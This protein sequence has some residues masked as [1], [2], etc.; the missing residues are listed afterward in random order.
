MSDSND[1]SGGPT[2]QH[3]SRRQLLSGA[4][5]ALGAAFLMPDQVSARLSALGSEEE[6]RARQRLN[7]AI[8][9]TNTTVVT[10][11][12]HRPPLVDVA[13]AVSGDR[14][15]AIGPT[16]SVLAQ[17]P[18]AEVIDGRNKALLP[19]V[20]NC[21]A[22]L[23]A[24]IA[25]GFNEDFG[26]PNR[27]GL[28]VSPGSLLS[29]E[30]RTLMSVI[31]AVESIRCGAT[32]VVQYTGGIAPEAEA[33]AN[34]GL[35]WVFAEAAND[36]IDGTVMSP[37]R[38]AASETPRFSESM[39]EAGMQRIQDLFSAWHGHDDGRVQVFP[40]VVHTENASPELLQAVRAFAEE[41]DL[42][43]TI[44]L[45]QTHAEVDYMLRYH[46]V[47]PT[48]YLY[49]HDFLGPRLFAAHARYADER[50]I[51]LLASTNT[52]V[53]HQAAMA[54][55]RGVSPPIPALREAGCTICLGTD[56]NNNDMFAVMKVAMLTERI[57]RGGDDEHP[58]LLPQP[59]DI[60]QDAALGGAHAIQQPDDLGLLEVGRKADIIVLDTLK[61]HL[62]PHGRVLSVWLHNGQ[63]SDVESVMVDGEFIMR[64]HRVLTVDEEAI[65][66]EA[67]S[68]GRRVWDEVQGANPVTPPGR[69]MSWG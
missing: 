54:A 60:L 24:T 52:I 27:A 34:T 62:V 43:Y 35:R 56:N 68:V 33:L 22:H 53:A 29:T 69:T 65:V 4:G 17:Y 31:A 64:D 66:A 58:G 18:G 37:E 7:D 2:D 1:R 32:T 26:F 57:R 30:E 45:N 14:I 36:R 25:R 28:D 41:H 59:E 39:R 51:E 47:R 67:N 44:H 6:N 42:G 40:S 55:N 5:A 38:L 50:E 48:E 8:V 9:F 16:D 15:A 3:L 11:D 23:S 49:Q 10:G 13:L 19:G 20:M 61:P 63:P 46:G 21:H 12:A